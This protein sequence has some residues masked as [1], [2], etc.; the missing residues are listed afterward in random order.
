[1]RLPHRLESFKGTFVVKSDPIFIHS[2]FRSGS[3]YF[4][5]VFRR[6]ARGYWC[7][8]EPFHERIRLACNDPES[9]LEYKDDVAVSLRH[10]QP[11]TPY[12]WEFS[13]ISEEFK[14]KLCKNFSYDT[15]FGAQGETSDRIG[16]FLDILVKRAQGRPVFECCRTFARVALLREK[17]GGTHIFLWRNAWD[18]WWSY[19]ITK[20]FE[21]TNLMILNAEYLPD[22]FQCLRREL[23]F[24]EYHHEDIEAE[25]EHFRTQPLTADQNYLL[26]YTT[27]AFGLL[28]NLQKSDMSINI[29]S[30]SSSESYRTEVTSEL[31]QKGIDG[32]DFSDCT[33]PQASY[34]S[35]EQAFF[36]AIEARV[37]QMLM[38][39]G[40]TR[41]ELLN[42]LELR[43]EHAPKL[44][45]KK[46]SASI[47]RK[48]LV[49]QA[50]RAR[51][52]VREYETNIAYLKTELRGM[53]LESERHQAE[54]ER[55]TE[56]LDQSRNHSQWLEDELVQTRIHL[57]ESNQHVQRLEGELSQ[58][59][60]RAE[61][62]DQ[63]AQSLE[64]DLADAHQKVARL[65][66]QICQ[67]DRD[68]Q[69]LRKEFSRS[70]S[71]MEHL[72]TDYGALRE[73]TT[74]VENELANAREHAHW[75]EAELNQSRAHMADL[76]L[77]LDLVY[78]S[79]SWQVTWPIRAL[80]D[81]LRSGS[82]GI[83]AVGRWVAGT[84]KSLAKHFILIGVRWTKAD[85]RMLGFGKKLLALFPHLDGRMR[86]FVR[87]Q[88]L[89]PI[90]E[91][92]EPPLA[93]VS[94]SY[95]Q[96]E[97]DFTKWDEYPPSVRKI[98]QDLKGAIE[99]FRS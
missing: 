25:F 62:L 60:S 97:A 76:Q 30:L 33:I 32:L 10:P 94:P 93:T 11:K 31:A 5:N 12:F 18:Q 35:K 71:E 16:R 45:L 39:N 84:I 3:T 98:C 70:Q 21:A 83:A 74:H 99:R 17:I 15:F 81:L 43:R 29:D 69:W 40:Y 73:H 48:E 1:M 26:F 59:H 9:L 49:D 89:L 63:R 80:H 42:L 77:R 79:R 27:W 54:H 34:T 4:L 24:S 44:R 41:S 91:H 14:G 82:R 64:S 96:D 53:G 65:E 7:Y 85:P 28:E 67:A 19:K 2:L 23:N 68:Q 90:V 13:L 88:E 66:G 55:L 37:H 57:E 92:K 47:I 46:Q 58:F 38:Q 8:Y 86:A 52:L 95:H 56:A 61:E 87:R 78:R 6:S 20:Y 50:S 72:Q 51:D 75:L 36:E 22:I